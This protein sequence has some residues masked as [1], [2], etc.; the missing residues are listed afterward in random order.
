MD[1]A[2]KALDHNVAPE[3]GERKYASEMR[4]RTS[5]RRALR[6]EQQDEVA[7]SWFGLEFLTDAQS[8]SLA[9]IVVGAVI[10][11]VLFLPLGLIGWSGLALGWRLAIAAL[12]RWPAARPSPSTWA[13]ASWARVRCRTWTV[14]RRSARRCAIRAPTPAGVTVA[15]PSDIHAVEDPV[16]G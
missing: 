2:E 7:E 15:A 13:S 5:D 12:V 9:G 11:A 14:A 6:R 1:R 8:G 4:A 16:P 3:P 10:G